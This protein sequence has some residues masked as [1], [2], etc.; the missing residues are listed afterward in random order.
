MFDLHQTKGDLEDVA[1]H[2]KIDKAA[3]QTTSLLARLG[4]DGILVIREVAEARHCC[5]GLG[6][7]QVR[8]REG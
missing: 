2:G 7:L 8:T 3:P 6:G 1:L 4:E 5:D